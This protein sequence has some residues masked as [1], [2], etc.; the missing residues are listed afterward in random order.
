MKARIYEI[1]QGAA[2]RNAEILRDE[3]NDLFFWNDLK[4]QD[5]EVGDRIFFV[6]RTGG[7]SLYTTIGEKG[8]ATTRS[9]DSNVSFE[10]KG[11]TYKVE[12]AF[13]RFKRFVRFDVVQEA[14]LKADDEWT[15]LGSSEVNDL[16]LGDEAPAPNPNRTT[17]IQQLKRIFQDGEGARALEEI[18]ELL[19]PS[20]QLIEG[21]VV[22]DGSDWFEH[23]INEFQR[24]GKRVLWWTN[25]PSGKEVTE[26]SLDHTLESRQWFGL[27]YTKDRRARYRARVIDWATA[28]NYPSKRWNEQ[29]KIAGYEPDFRNY[30]STRNG[31]E[32]I[33]KV[34]FLVDRFEAVIPEISIERF[35]LHNGPSSLT[36]ANMI[37]YRSIQDEPEWG[38]AFV[39]IEDP[40]VNAFRQYLREVAK[41]QPNTAE[42]YINWM[43]RLEAMLNQSH[44]LPDPG[45][46]WR[47]KDEIGRINGIV[48]NFGSAQWQEL[49][50]G[51]TNL[52]RAPWDHWMAFN[53]TEMSSTYSITPTGVIDHVHKYVTG[54]GFRFSK[55]EI[56]NFY[57]ALRAKP[58]VILA[59]IS[60]TG[61]SQLPKQFAK[62]IGMSSDQVRMIAVSPDWTD[63]SDLI[64]F[65]NLNSKFIP[66]D[67]TLAIQAAQ[68]DPQRPYFFILDEMN[69]ARVEHY[70]SDFLS[71]I[72][73]RERT[74]GTITTRPLLRREVLNGSTNSEEFQGVSWPENLYLIGTVNMDETTHA[75]SRKVLD[76]ANS[77]E[78]N[79]VDLQW[80]T[81]A[82]A[83]Q[84]LSDVNN[85]LFK[86]LYIA[87]REIDEKQRETLKDD[88][89][90]L[91]EVNAILEKADLHFAYRVRDE[92]AF[93][94]LMNRDF[95]LMSPEEAMDYQLMQ[96]VLPRIHGSSERIQTLLLQLLNRLAG[97]DLATR[98]LDLDDVTNKVN[99]HLA[100][101]ARYPRSIRKIM[102]MLRRFDE[103][104]FTS[105]WL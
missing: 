9:E 103:D 1:K 49:N 70:F 58:F 90:L 95:G 78:M 68:R 63:G 12:D 71:V 6:N 38:P 3:E 76:R 40:D 14:P 18:E 15:S 4:F 86:T 104:R 31:K 79:E 91:I 25:K 85:D 43:R 75:F 59:G 74:N 84:P 96:K 105:F 45:N 24:Y 67:L 77:I 27:Y 2:A 57:L 13:D 51:Q 100:A 61:K 56:A 29:G 20:Q 34:A 87:S 62:A 22:V 47:A 81:I 60:G 88:L 64:G 80:P 48:S 36:W 30:R 37:P 99:G 92:V 26:R 16:W 54:C 10:Y 44:L 83:M 52:T 72:E 46:I 50:Q 69:L 11:H 93:Y 28:E 17:R 21:V 101:G 19:G 55:A 33:A 89:T 66:K 5:F 97:L 65:T 8:I 32:H 98:E 73:T 53:K 82:Q 42:V 102:F 94:L 39:P 7:W 41:V 23:E 35:D